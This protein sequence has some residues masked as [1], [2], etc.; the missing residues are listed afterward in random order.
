MSTSEPNTTADR[1]VPKAVVN[2]AIAGTVLIGIGAAV[3]SFTA[4]ADLAVRAGTPR[5]LSVV[6]PVIVDGVIVV[7]TI[8]IVAL[9]SAD[10]RARSY[11]WLLLGFGAVISIIANGAHAV[12]AAA[13]TTPQWM[14]VTVASVPPVVLLSITHLTVI[15]ARRA[16]ASQPA[17]DVTE[18]P[19]DP[20]RQPATPPARHDLDA[21]LADLLGGQT[22]QPVIDQPAATATAQDQPAAT[23][24][25][26]DQPAAS[27]RFTDASQPSSHAAAS[28]P[29][30]IWQLPASQPPARQQTSDG[31]D[32]D[33][34]VISPAASHRRSLH[35]VPSSK[36]ESTKHKE[37]VAARRQSAARKPAA[38]GD[39]DLADWIRHTVSTGHKPT[40]VAAVA[41]GVATS[42]SAARR[43]IKVLRESSPEIF[44]SATTVSEHTA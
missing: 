26:Q 15:L 4:L 5:R 39:A 27:H 25:A 13:A 14:A 28:Q 40:A 11:A 12:V 9:R 30:E 33:M 36:L 18:T 21:D 31:D 22:D 35:A 24:T 3:L 16:R 37:E 19:P 1:P 10:S 41:A 2:A 34:T 42:E 43:R 29:R 17:T 6:W 7:A 8:A 20:T 32:G 38:K 44:Q 23:A